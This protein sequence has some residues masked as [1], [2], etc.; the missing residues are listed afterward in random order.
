MGGGGGFVGSVHRDAQN[1]VY[2]YDP[3]SDTWRILPGMK[4]GR[5]SVG[6]AVIGGKVHAIGGR[7]ADG[8]TI[9][10]HE[11]FDLAT[12]SWRELAPL[13]KAR[14]HAAVAGATDWRGAS[15]RLEGRDLVGQFDFHLRKQNRR[16][17]HGHNAPKDPC[18]TSSSV[19]VARVSEGRARVPYAA[20][21]SL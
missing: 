2:E 21:R 3:T 20:R 15:Y 7:N 19:G 12:N 10:T 4:A 1:A 5:G 18:G 11:A 14:D 6:V 16:G 8:Q 13:P 9:A 17:T